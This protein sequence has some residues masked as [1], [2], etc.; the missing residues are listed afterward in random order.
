M[1][2]IERKKQFFTVKDPKSMNNGLPFSSQSSSH[3]QTVLAAETWGLK[4]AIIFDD[5]IQCAECVCEA[6][7]ID[8]CKEFQKVPKSS[9]Q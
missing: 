9:V 5:F 2:P 4:S 7:T 3:A 6:F 8:L 1:K